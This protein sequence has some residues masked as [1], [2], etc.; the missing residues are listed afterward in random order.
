VPLTFDIMR[1]RKRVIRR[2]IVSRLQ[3]NGATFFELK[4]QAQFF[5]ILTP[6]TLLLYCSYY[7]TNNEAPNNMFLG[8]DRETNNEVTAI[9]KQ[10]PARN[11]GNTFGSRVFYVVRSEAISRDRPSSVS[12]V[13]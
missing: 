9:A 5:S 1:S 7:N 2:K 13:E 8:N 4:A 10:R 6:V 3:Y 12:A 11:N